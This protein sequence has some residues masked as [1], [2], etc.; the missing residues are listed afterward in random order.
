LARP[1]VYTLGQEH[2]Y[3]GLWDPRLQGA[4]RRAYPRLDAVTGLTPADARRYREV[5]PPGVLVRNMPN[6][7]PDVRAARSDLSSSVVVSAGRLTPQKGF[8]L[9]VEAFRIVA[10]RHPAWSLHI[11]G[12]GPMRQQLARQL[13][14]SGLKGTVVLKGFSGSLPEALAGASIFALSSRFEGFSLALVEAMG[15]GLPPVSFACPHGPLEIITN[16]VDGLLVPPENVEALAAGICALIEDPQRR[17]ELGA[18]ARR[19][20]RSYAPDVVDAAWDRLI[21][22]LTARPSGVR[23]G[24]S[25]RL[26]R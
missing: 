21:D 9:L 11:Y 10:E 24:V 13:R 14:A 15:V 6:A 2:Q 1:S 20:V 22:D 3:L 17:A 26:S 18:A 19:R 16:D 12:V 23:R 4:M 7:V 5:L 25:A 8:D